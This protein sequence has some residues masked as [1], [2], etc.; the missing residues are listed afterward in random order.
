MSMPQR[1]S[2]I[3]VSQKV[4]AYFAPVDRAT[5]SPVIFD[6]GKDGAFELESPPAPWLDL[7]WIDNFIRYT[8]L[9]DGEVSAGAPAAVL[10]QDRSAIAGHIEFDFREWGKLQMALAGGSQHINVLAVGTGA[11]SSPCGGTAPP[12]VAVLDGS[13]ANEIIV[14]AG[15]LD[16]FV[17]GDIL[18]IDR[19][20]QQETGYVGTGVTAGFVQDPADVM[21]DPNYIRRITFNVGRVAGKTADSLLLAQPLIG[22]AP[23]S[24]AALQ[25]V[26][27]FLD[28][29][30][31]S[32]IQEWSAVFVHQE[33]SGGRVCFY[34]PR[35]SATSSLQNPQ[36]GFQRETAITISQPF[37]A[38]ALHACFAA[39]PCRD[40]A[41][42]EKVICYRSYFPATAAAVY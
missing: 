37:H 27:A 1:S 8:D 30:G 6:P 35:L 42:G 7:G 18:A 41:D 17:V 10:R 25:K 32:Y 5:E 33:E 29:E 4:R 3:P 38:L 26:V 40:Q 9:V 24:G 15:A 21:R 36:R 22:G 11:V 20:Y 12:P 2:M 28:R 19:D 39:L 31:G 14:G 23:Q 34:Y 13:T 16:D